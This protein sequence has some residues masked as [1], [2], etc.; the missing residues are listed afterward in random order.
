MF[1]YDTRNLIIEKV[2]AL[3][4]QSTLVDP[5]FRHHDY[6]RISV[7]D[8]CNLKCRYCVPDGMHHCQ[9][10]KNILS[11]EEIEQIVKV[12]AELGVRKIRL[13]GGE[14][15]LRKNLPVLVEKLHSIPG[16]EDIALTTNGIYLHKYASELKRAGLNRV[17]ISLDTLDP[18]TFS[19]ITRGGTLK[20]VL[21]SLEASLAVGFAPIKINTVLMKDINEADIERLIELAIDAP[22]HVRFI[23][24]MPIGHAGDLWDSK[25]VSLDTV[26]LK[27]KKFGTL[28]PYGKVKNNGPAEQFTF[29]GAKG[30]IGFIHPISSHFCDSCNRLRLTSDGRLKPC[31]YWQDEVDLRP[32]LDDPY[33]MKKRFYQAVRRKPQ[34]HEMAQLLKS[35][36]PTTRMMSQIGG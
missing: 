26:R 36:I 10:E 9:P 8:R 20:D 1:W 33:E 7:T 12:G 22:L 25:Y 6:L 21:D 15:L 23:E 34:Q 29:A 24:Y 35:G 18:A 3:K 14:P 19:Y 32:V 30:S 28:Q 5:F 16:I 27:A 13:T 11:Y 17:N 31:L 2:H 4:E